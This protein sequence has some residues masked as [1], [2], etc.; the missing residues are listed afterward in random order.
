MCQRI[1]R[2]VLESY[3]Y[4]TQ[5]VCGEMNLLLTLPNC[6]EVERQSLRFQPGASLSRP[7][8]CALLSQVGHG[9]SWWWSRLSVA[10]GAYSR[11]STHH[12]GQSPGDLQAEMLK[13]SVAHFNLLGEISA[14]PEHKP[15][16]ESQQDI[17]LKSPAECCWQCHRTTLIPH[18]IGHGSSGYRPA[19]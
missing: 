8:G 5:H 17:L 1:T 3:W 10:G 4:V 7:V 6:G 11:C 12:L 14:S 19:L 15:C 13:F 2:N 16:C 9:G 18:R